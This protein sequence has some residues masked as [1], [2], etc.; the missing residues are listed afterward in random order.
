MNYIISNTYC[1]P[2]CG[3]F[4]LTTKIDCCPICFTENIELVGDKTIKK[5]TPDL[6][7]NILNDVVVLNFV[8]ND[9]NLPFVFYYW[10]DKSFVMGCFSTKNKAINAV[11]GLGFSGI[12][13]RLIFETNEKK[14]IQ[15]L[16]PF[17]LK[18]EI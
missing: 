17:V 7:I 10:K 4:I 6:F 9:I 1:C 3:K 2:K 18:H 5:R 12:K 8:K 14:R 16:K 13:E 15:K 11:I